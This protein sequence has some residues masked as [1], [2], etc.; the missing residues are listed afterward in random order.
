MKWTQ[1]DEFREQIDFFSQTISS[2]R[3]AQAYLFK[4]PEGVGKFHLA[5]ELA[6]N[7]NCTADENQ[8][9]G[10]CSCPSCRKAKN[11]NHPDLRIILPL[12]SE[13]ARLITSK[14]DKFNEA[15]NELILKK[16][17]RPFSPYDFE[18]DGIISIEMIR[19]LKEDAYKRAQEGK[20]RVFIIDRI[21][22][23][24]LPAAQSLLKVLEEPS[25]TTLFILTTSQVNTVLST[26]VSRC[27]VIPF[28]KLSA[29]FIKEEIKKNNLTETE[30]E[31]IS[32]LAGGSLGKIYQY[33]A[34]PDLPA[35]RKEAFKII[36]LVCSSGLDEIVEFCYSVSSQKSN[37]YIRNLL[38]FLL[39]FYY[40]LF[41]VNV[42]REGEIKNRDF[43]GEL[44]ALKGRFALN[45]II[46]GIRQ[47]EQAD[48]NLDRNINPLL[49]LINLI[50]TLKQKRK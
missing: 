37:F 21:E 31:V 23:L 1:A 2:N 4:G 49:N 11:Y 46:D 20:K 15:N 5:L 17:A 43:S 19:S 33:L 10:A 44:C 16:I 7:L 32:C 38:L 9:G 22:F 30:S 3:L 39:F 34:D 14:T 27:Q 40:D 48:Q 18:K 13:Q 42:S 36:G 45:E 25:E 50:L 47:I 26:I 29:R 35:S 12:Q 41:S 6:L 28:K 8:G 24:T